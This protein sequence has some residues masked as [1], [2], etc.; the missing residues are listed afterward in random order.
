MPIKRINEFPEGSGSLSN[1]DVFLFMDDPSGSGVTKKISLSEISDA[2]GGGGGVGSLSI[3][4]RYFDYVK[5]VGL[6]GTGD[7]VAV[8]DINDDDNEY[9][10][11]LP[12]SVTFLG[13]S[14]NEVWLNSNS[15]LTFL[16]MDANSPAGYSV[17]WPQGP[18]NLGVPAIVAG[19][20]DRNI[21][22]YYYGSTDDGRFVIRYEGK[23]INWGGDSNVT[24]TR[25]WEI[26]FYE[27]EPDKISLVVSD[28][29]PQGGVWGMHDGVKWVD[30]YEQLPRLDQNADWES[31]INSVDIYTKEPSN[32]NT[33]KF[34]GQ[35]VE[36][37]I[38]GSKAF[39]EV[40]P[41]QGMLNIDL[42]GDGNTTISSAGYGLTLKSTHN[43]SIT[44]ASNGDVN[45]TAKTR[46]ND[47]PGNGYDV[48]INGGI[49]VGTDNNGGNVYIQAGDKTG[50]GSEGSIYLRCPNSSSQFQFTNNVL[51]RLIFPNT[52]TIAQGTFD[53]G[54]GGGN[55]ISL[56][57][58][59]G[60]ELNWQGGR[61][62]STLDNG[63]SAANILCDSA[64]E[65]PGSGIDNVQ[66]D[67][68]GITFSDGTFQNTAWTGTINSTQ[69]S[70]FNSSVSG[71]LPV[72]D[73]IAGSGISISESYGSFTINSKLVSDPVG[74]SG[75][76]SITNI[77]QISQTDYDNLGSYDPNTVYII[78][79]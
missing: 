63:I 67:I 11:E 75:A 55:G 57:C 30:I 78:N 28:D 71:L 62:K 49:A 23:A 70:D 34:I 32:A 44:L 43:E 10:I 6:Y 21:T 50:S 76:L 13:Q 59:V 33:L 16:S 14:Y 1:D 2:I 18:A 26:W 8:T 74:I 29:M 40:N 31:L 45:I 37:Y 22:N 52:T 19:A 65:F 60:Y 46:D 48:Y 36:T 7:L 27:N 72:K 42:D 15:Y 12:F 69:I 61:L 58:V 41:L 53:N 3:E 47:N 25:I 77:V 4:E 56:N 54:T 66:I 39:I 64:L 9:L 68:S 38:E 24:A 17:Y 20:T 79:T 35:G 73:I 5:D 51:P